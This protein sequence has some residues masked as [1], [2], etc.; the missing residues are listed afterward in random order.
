MLLPHLN[1]LVN[2]N[3]ECL[4]ESVHCG[5][6]NGIVPDSFNILRLL[7]NRLEDE[8]NSKVINQLQIEIPDNFI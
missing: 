6:G 2:I 8:N 5:S 4:N 3:I 1:I 7:L